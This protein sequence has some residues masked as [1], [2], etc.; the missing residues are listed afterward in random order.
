MLCLVLSLQLPES[1]KMSRRRFRKQAQPLK[2]PENS[3]R[4]LRAE[5]L[6]LGESRGCNT[7]WL[8]FWKGTLSRR[9]KQDFSSN[10]NIALFSQNCLKQEV[11]HRKKSCSTPLFYTSVKIWP[12]Q[13]QEPS[14]CLSGLT[15]HVLR[16]T[17]VSISRFDPLPLNENTPILSQRVT[18]LQHWAFGAGSSMCLPPLLGMTQ[19][20][21]H[22]GG[23]SLHWV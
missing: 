9:R 6:L 15:V 7:Q 22:K 12:S 4:N 13:T 1:C 2:I 5:Y 21:G 16:D 10:Q 3:G 8:S 17:A 20:A 18:G 23:T 11:S 19:G 14:P